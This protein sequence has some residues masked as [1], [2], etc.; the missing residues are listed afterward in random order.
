M[1]P[2]RGPPTRSV[3]LATASTGVSSSALHLLGLECQV[4]G[5]SWRGPAWPSQRG[6]CGGLLGREVGAWFSQRRF[7]LDWAPF[8]DRACRSIP[9]RV[10]LHRG[11]GRGTPGERVTAR[12]AFVGRKPT[13]RPAQLSPPCALRRHCQWP[14]GGGPPLEAFPA[15][16]AN[17]GHGQWVSVMHPPPCQEAPARGRPRDTRPLTLEAG[18]QW[19]PLTS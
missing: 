16:T 2:A 13:T 14:G 6:T 11:V 3:A 9:R 10:V 8:E 4:G 12:W 1:L 18:E 5:G 7:A 17:G 15:L 19:P